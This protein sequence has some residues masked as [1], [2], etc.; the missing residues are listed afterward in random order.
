M[1]VKDMSGD[2][3]FPPAVIEDDSPVWSWATAWFLAAV[4]AIAGG[5]FFMVSARSVEAPSTA[6]PAPTTCMAEQNAVSAAESRERDARWDDASPAQQRRATRAVRDAERALAQCESQRQA[7]TA[8]LQKASD[9]RKSKRK[10]GL[11][12]IG[13][14][15]LMAAGGV[16]AAF[17]APHYL[18]A[19]AERDAELEAEARARAEAEA[20]ARAEAEAQ[21]HAEAQARAEAEARARAQAEAEARARSEEQQRQ[22][23]G[24]PEDGGT[25]PRQSSFDDLI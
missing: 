25:S 1:M 8:A 2:N 3:H 20:R 7:A 13:F 19:K 24:R 6:V 16:G 9:D 5:V 21:A 11:F 10:T 17:F 18:R 4:V 12:L 22:Q 23:Y 14:G 15:I